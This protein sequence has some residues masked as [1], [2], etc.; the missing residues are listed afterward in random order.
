MICHNFDESDTN[1]SIGQML[2]DTMGKR[3]E[4]MGR[5]QT[6]FLDFLFKLRAKSKHKSVCIR[7]IRSIR[8]P[9]VAQNPH[10]KVY[11]E[12]RLLI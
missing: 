12:K 6:D 9:I 10:T 5:I 7:Q 1:F 4:R 3:I 2:C 8:F 11:A